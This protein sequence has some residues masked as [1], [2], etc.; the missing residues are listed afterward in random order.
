MQNGH[1]VDDRY[2]DET[3]RAITVF[4]L[5]HPPSERW[6]PL[7]SIGKHKEASVR[8]EVCQMSSGQTSQTV[9]ITVVTSC[10]TG[11]FFL[12]NTSDE[13]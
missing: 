8:G 3:C 13:T 7:L 12:K 11:M 4:R 2:S 6:F 5:S 10:R 1:Y 9:F